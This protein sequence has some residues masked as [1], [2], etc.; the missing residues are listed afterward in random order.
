MSLPILQWN[1]ITD[2][3][4][5]VKASVYI[6]PTLAFLDMVNRNSSN[7]NRT[8]MIHIKDTDHPMYEN[9]AIYATLDKTSDSPECR[10]NFFNT[11]GVYLLTCNMPWYGYPNR[12]GSVTIYKGV[13]DDTEIKKEFEKTSTS[14]STP[15]PEPTPRVVENYKDHT[16]DD[17]SIDEQDDKIIEP[18]EPP[19]ERRCKRGMS[20][21]TL[22]TIGLLLIILAAVVAAFSDKK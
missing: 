15:T 16:H 21:S 11:T 19:R 13:L 20:S 6:K 4:G 14:T 22:L 10:Q 2:S 9:R 5:E 7:G 18:Y 3:Y 8:L 1:P 17:E 12:Y